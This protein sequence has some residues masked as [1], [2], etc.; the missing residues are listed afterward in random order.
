[1]DAI[2]VVLTVVKPDPFSSESGGRDIVGVL[3]PEVEDDLTELHCTDFNRARKIENKFVGLDV[4]GG[5]LFLRVV[6]ANKVFK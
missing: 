4:L 2:P 3:V 1:M 5:E 6:L